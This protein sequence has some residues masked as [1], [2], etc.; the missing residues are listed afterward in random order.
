M[1]CKKCG[2]ELNSGT[3][4][5]I[6]S[7]V[8]RSFFSSEII[9]LTVECNHCGA[10]HFNYVNMDDLILEKRQHHRGEIKNEAGIYQDRQ[11]QKL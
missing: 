4:I 1:Q 11:H 8:K 9:D 10:K 6:G 7:F 2:Q 3:A 5:I